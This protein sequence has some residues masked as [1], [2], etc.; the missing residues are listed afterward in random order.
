[1]ES[2]SGQ[3]FHGTHLSIKNDPEFDL[4]GLIAFPC[5]ALYLDAAYYIN[6]G[7]GILGF[8]E[9]RSDRAYRA[10]GLNGML[11][12]ILAL[13]PLDV[14]EALLDEKLTTNYY[15]QLAFKKIISDEFG[16]IIERLQAN[17]SYIDMKDR[18]RGLGVD[19]ELLISLTRL[20]G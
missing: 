13:I 6:F 9:I 15:L 1:M 11:D 10:G 7:L 3:E 2:L 19:V 18:L 4:I 17:V 8:P 16:D 14:C 20:S 5:Q 12:E